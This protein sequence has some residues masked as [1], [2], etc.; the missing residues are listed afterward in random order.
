LNKPRKV[1]KPARPNG[2]LTY[3]TAAIVN[4]TRRSDPKGADRLARWRGHYV[5]VEAHNIVNHSAS[6]CH[7][8]GD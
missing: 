8:C 4:S 6:Y 5:F 1:A 7:T 2:T 3:V